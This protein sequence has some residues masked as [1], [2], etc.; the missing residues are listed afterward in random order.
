MRALCNTSMSCSAV[1][2]MRARASSS[3]LV[4]LTCLAFS[5]VTSNAWHKPSPRTHGRTDGEPANPASCQ[6]HVSCARLPQAHPKHTV[7]QQV[8]PNRNTQ[9]VNKSQPS[10]TH[11]APTSLTHPKHTVRQQVSPPPPPSTAQ[12]QRLWRQPQRWLW[13]SLHRRRSDPQWHVGASL[14]APPAVLQRA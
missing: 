2:S 1:M 3:S 6:H 8:S 5:R 9:C 13:R 11:S 10:Q 7:C 4:I 12:A 14:H